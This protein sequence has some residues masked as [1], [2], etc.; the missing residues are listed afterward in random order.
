MLIDLHVH[1]STSSCSRLGI[2]EILTHARRLGL[3]GVCITDHD[4][5]D[6]RSHI[7]DGVQP[8]GL[9]VV[10]GMEYATTQG[11]FLLF[12]PFET[13]EPGLSA[14]SVL[15][16]VREAGGA[17]VVAHPCRKV[18]PADPAVAAAGLLAAVER[19]NG[20]NTSGENARALQ[21]ESGGSEG[22][23]CSVAGSDAHTLQ[24]LGCAPTRFLVPVRS[25]AGLIT[26]LNQGLCEPGVQA[27]L[28]GGIPSL[29]QERSGSFPSSPATVSTHAQSR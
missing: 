21:W 23:L 1:S 19:V 26:A 28:R 11:D 16:R 2:A 24:E 12:G 20:R 7:Q 15:R 3:D 18:R 25:K 4:T 8:D 22:G 5:M 6:A 13:L 29:R 14:G 10:V 9:L 17:A 27:P